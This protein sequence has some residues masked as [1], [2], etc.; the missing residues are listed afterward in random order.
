MFKQ[1]HLYSDL[2]FLNYKTLKLERLENRRE[3]GRLICN[4]STNVRN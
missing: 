1:N 3:G 2:I 4:Y